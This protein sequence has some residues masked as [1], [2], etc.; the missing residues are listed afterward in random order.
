MIIRDH[1]SLLFNRKFHVKK[2]LTRY[3]ENKNWNFNKII[4]WI[5]IFIKVCVIFFLC[6][7]ELC[8][9][10]LFLPK[11]RRVIKLQRCIQHA[12]VLHD[13]FISLI[14]CHTMCLPSIFFYF[15]FFFYFYFI[16][17]FSLHTWVE[18]VTNEILL[19][20]KNKTSGIW[21][22]STGAW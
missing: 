8:V 6:A 19:F 17:V 4:F 1:L 5:N 2:K 3:I 11:K 14:I 15:F 18:F 20:Y 13:V 21:I 7:L 10:I 22:L 16:L 12:I 9:N